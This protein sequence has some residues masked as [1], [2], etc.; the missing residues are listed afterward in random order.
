MEGNDR[1]LRY[2]RPLLKLSGEMLGGV[3]GTGFDRASVER[4][5]IDVKTLVDNG[6]TPAIVL[7][8]GNFFRGARGHLP[9]LRRHRADFVGML[10]TMMNAVCFADHLEAIG[11]KTTVFSAVE[12]PKI[13]EPYQIDHAISSLRTGV[14]CLFA[15]GTGAPYFSTDTASALRAV[16]VGCDVLIKATKVDGVYDQDPMKD[17]QA[18]KFDRI[19]YSEVLRLGLGVMD[20]MAIALCRENQMPLQVLSL[21]VPENLLRACRGEPIGTIVEEE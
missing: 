4:Y 7:G 5:A 17:P 19:T 12:A 11:V 13:C 18:K 15:G 21:A 1:S 14:V 8:G 16:E 2:R 20:A 3:S 6:V 10:A 9:H